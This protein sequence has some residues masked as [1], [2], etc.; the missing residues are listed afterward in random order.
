MKSKEAIRKKILVY[1]NLI[2]GSRRIDRLDPIVKLMIDNITNEIYLLN[3]KIDD[4]EATILE[5]IAK[6]ITTAEYISV[7]PSH[8]VIQM[9]PDYPLY[10]LTS[11]TPLFMNEVPSGIFTKKIET[12]AFHPVTDVFLWDA[13][14]AYIFHDKKLFTM[15]SHN[16][17]EV[18]AT[19]SKRVTYNSIWLGLEIAEG[20]KNLKGFSFYIDFPHL[21]EIHDYY[22]ILSYTTCFIDGKEVKLKSGYPL[23]ADK[24]Y[25]ESDKSVLSL[26]DEHYLAIDEEVNLRNIQLKSLP[27]E[28]REVID[29]ELISDMP[30]ML[31]IQLKFLPS[32]QPEDLDNIYIAINAFPASNKKLAYIPIIKDNLKKTTMLPGNRYE[33]LL[34]VHQVIDMEGNIYFPVS[35]E[36]DDM[37][38][39]Y[40]IDKINR[41]FQEQYHL[42]DIIERLRDIIQDEKV[43]FPEMDIDLLNN[44]ISAIEESESRVQDRTDRN[45]RDDNKIIGK[46]AFTPF[47]ETTE[48]TVRYWLTFGESLN[49]IAAGKTFSAHKNSPLHG[50]EALSITEI[51][52][53]KE[54]KEVSE[55][56]SINKYILTSKNKIFTDHDILSFC[57]SE[58]KDIIHRVEVRLADKVSLKPYEGLIRSIHVN[59]YPLPKYA[60]RI[61][62]KGILRRLK[63]QLYQRSP[64]HYNYTINIIE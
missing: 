10:I 36:I 34:D 39:T 64:Q 18:K 14:L 30:S 17:K 43:A 4:I 7:R 54:F 63:T 53:G 38:G 50:I 61:K 41:I 55:L 48:I 20:I 21:S 42:T 47:E 32:F 59:L 33:K 45:K 56:P 19:T 5:K 58:L 23:T 62:K 25:T 60:E 31:W 29:P 12:I 26:Y 13:R 15:L 40:H 57:E 46:I 51:H 52:G 27:D 1:I 24:E 2:W 6:I 49:G 37:E 16:E 44:V 3:N 35:K 22:D 11:D 9:K 8:T 28:I